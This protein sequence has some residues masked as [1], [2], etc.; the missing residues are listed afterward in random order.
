VAVLRHQ[1]SS[2]L[3]SRRN[4]RR[5]PPQ[6]CTQQPFKPTQFLP[7]LL[8]SRKMT[9]ELEDQISHIELSSPTMESAPRSPSP[10]HESDA[11]MLSIPD[12]EKPAY[13]EPLYTEINI[14]L[15]RLPSPPQ[16][17]PTT[18][19]PS[20]KSTTH[21]RARSLSTFSPFRSRSSSSPSRKSEDSPRVR[22]SILKNRE[23]AAAMDLTHQSKR[24]LCRRCWCLV[25][26]CSRR[27]PGRL[28]TEEENGRMG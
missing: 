4:K 3:G 16:S 23:V 13:E 1:G 10:T 12:F 17:I 8:S 25:R 11:T 2:S 7:V 18:T 26:S 19:S 15:P 20:I 28:R 27:G 21:T 9:S 6:I 24:Q 22:P 14:P 5:P